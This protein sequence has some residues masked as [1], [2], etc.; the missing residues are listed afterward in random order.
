MGEL[1]ESSPSPTSMA[2]TCDLDH[3]KRTCAI[4]SGGHEPYFESMDYACL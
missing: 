4:P 1:T 2:Q 3:L